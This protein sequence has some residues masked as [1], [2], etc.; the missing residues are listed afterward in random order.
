MKIAGK[1]FLLIV[2]MCTGCATKTIKLDMT[3]KVYT[4]LPNHINLK[5]EIERKI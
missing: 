4:P 3:T 5:L 2:L 1:L